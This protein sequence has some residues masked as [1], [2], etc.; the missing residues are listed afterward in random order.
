[1]HSCLIIV[2]FYHLSVVSIYNYIPEIRLIFKKNDVVEITNM[3]SDKIFG[4]F[5]KIVIFRL[6]FT[7]LI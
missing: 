6:L 3:E 5:V 1:M 7:I 2:F 4:T